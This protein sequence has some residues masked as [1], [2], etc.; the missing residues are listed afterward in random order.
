MQSRHHRSSLHIPRHRQETGL[1]RLVDGR[2]RELQAQTKTA[3][4]HDVDCRP[5]TFEF[6]SN[7]SNLHPRDLSIHSASWV[8]HPLRPREQPVPPRDSIPPG[9]HPCLNP[10][11]H[12]LPT[13]HLPLAILQQGKKQGRPYDHNRRPPPNVPTPSTSTP[14]TRT[15]RDHCAPSVPSSPIPPSRPPPPSTPPIPRRHHDSPPARTRATI[16]R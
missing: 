12:P 6:S 13:H 16:L 5:S 9:N 10:V 1:E 2:H 15:S 14:R 4:W 8:P 11:L 3:G 7:T